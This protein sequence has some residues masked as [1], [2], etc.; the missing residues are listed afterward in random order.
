MRVLVVQ[1]FEDEGL[2]QLGAALAEAE[3]EIDLRRP[4]SG[5]ALPENASGHDALVVLGGGQDALDDEGSP[6][7]PALLSL[8][9][10]FGDGGRSVLGIC[11]GSQ[12]L[13]RA[14]GGDNLLGAA[15]E[16]GWQTVS[17]TEEG[18]A[19]AVLG[20]A[21]DD[22]PIFQWH[23]DTFTLP[24]GAAHLA[25]NEAAGNQAFRVGRAAYGLQFHFEADR[26]HVA[27]WNTVF[28]DLLAEN[29]PGWAAR[30]DEEAARHG[31]R[32]DAVGLAI[33]RAW[34]GTIGDGARRADD[35]RSATENA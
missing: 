6:Y 28:A 16:F 18:K 24:S 25:C 14:Y 26:P 9:R 31:P 33:A 1:N 35:A 13:A 29:Q 4:Y 23:Q 27:R 20:A 21:S 12:L 7:F 22:F 11:L 5:E 32:A 10:D 30:H 2:G 15:P 34:V 8:M 19:D 3:A 17:R